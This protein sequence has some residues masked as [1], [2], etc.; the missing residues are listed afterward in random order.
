MAIAIPISKNRK[1]YFSSL[2]NLFLQCEV[3]KL[4]LNQKIISHTFINGINF[5]I[6][7]AQTLIITQYFQIQL[8]L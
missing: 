3:N 5:F 8:H 2:K 7:L 4:T 6:N 1:I